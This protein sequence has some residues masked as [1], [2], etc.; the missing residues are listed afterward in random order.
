MRPC[1]RVARFVLLFLKS[2]MRGRG[3]LQRLRSSRASQDAKTL[4]D[5]VSLRRLQTRLPCIATK[6]PVDGPRTMLSNGTRIV[7]VKILSRCSMQIPFLSLGLSFHSILHPLFADDPLSIS[8]TTTSFF[9][10]C[11]YHTSLPCTLPR[12]SSHPRF[13]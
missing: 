2:R 7:K 9:F 8:L 6:L 13:P 4:P 12:H 3:G 5:I 1:C 11:G 10:L